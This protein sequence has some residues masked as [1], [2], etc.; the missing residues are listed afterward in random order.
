MAHVAAAVSLVVHVGFEGFQVLFGG[1]LGLLG[2]Y[3]F[4]PELKSLD[5]SLPGVAL[6]WYQCGA[7]AGCLVYT[8]WRKPVLALLAPLLGGLLVAS[9][10]AVLLGRGL[11]MAGTR[12]EF[13]GL[14]L[15]P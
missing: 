3:T 12:G 15:L 6:L 11:A 10:S 2:A 4:S 1:L 5:E 8:V 7:V 13:A 14:A 9:G